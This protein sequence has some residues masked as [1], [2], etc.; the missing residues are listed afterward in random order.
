MEMRITNEEMVDAFLRGRGLHK[1]KPD[2][3]VGLILPFLLLDTSYQIFRK[4]IRKIQTRFLSN[5]IKNELIE[6]YRKY[7]SEF[8]SY[9]N[10]DMV[11][12]INEKMQ[13][14]EDY[15]TNN[16]EILRISLLSDCKCSTKEQNEA[17]SYCLLCVALLRFASHTYSELYVK[18]TRSVFLESTNRVYYGFQGAEYEGFD[19]L[20]FLFESFAKAYCKTDINT[21]ATNDGKGIKDSMKAL[22]NKIINWMLNDKKE[23]KEQLEKEEN[24]SKN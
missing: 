8:F 21:L 23:E 24:E 1:D 22:S 3:S 5:R 7:N 20:I 4:S 12:A 16:T 18:A 10:D 9:F 14:L 6:A 17:L 11:D 19:K 2:V 15:V 13:D